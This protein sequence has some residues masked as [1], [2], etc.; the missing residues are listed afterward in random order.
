MRMIYKD[1]TLFVNLEGET[2]EYEIETIKNKMMNVI[3][4]YS[5]D[6]V[7]V[8]CNNSGNIKKLFKNV[9]N[10]DSTTKN[11]IDFK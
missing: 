1:D 4:E 10:S 5:V 9:I 11:K 8:D 2:T 3:R 7:V 6:N